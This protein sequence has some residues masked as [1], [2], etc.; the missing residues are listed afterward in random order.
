M[1]VLAAVVLGYLAGT[2]KLRKKAGK[3]KGNRTKQE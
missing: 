1:A 2:A 3:N